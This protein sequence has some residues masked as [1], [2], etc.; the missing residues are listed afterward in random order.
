MTECPRCKSFV[1]GTAGSTCNHCGGELIAGHTSPLAERVEAAFLDPAMPAPAL[2]GF[3]PNGEKTEYRLDRTEIAIGKA[4]HN[5][6]I[7]DDPTVSASHAILSLSSGVYSILDLASRNGTWVNGERLSNRSHLLQHGDR[8][9]IGQ[10]V[11][12]FRQPAQKFV[13]DSRT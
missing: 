1:P 9:Q 11:L 7:L 6:I 10:I 13:A 4:P 3:R 12:T 2:I 5:Q 8:I